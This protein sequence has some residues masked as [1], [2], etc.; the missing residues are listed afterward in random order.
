MGWLYV[1]RFTMIGEGGST[2][3]DSAISKLPSNYSIG[4][5]YFHPLFISMP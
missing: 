1:K 4:S 3:Q 2:K 5:I